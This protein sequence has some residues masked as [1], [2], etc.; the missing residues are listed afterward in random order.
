MQQG[1]PSIR[2]DICDAC[3]AIRQHDLQAWKITPTSGDKKA[4]Q[5]HHA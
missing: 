4:A 1:G 3:I 5:H 2:V